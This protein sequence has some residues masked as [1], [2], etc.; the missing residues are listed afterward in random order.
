MSVELDDVVTV[1]VPPAPLAAERPAEVAFMLLEIMGK[2]TFV[3][4][5]KLELPATWAGAAEL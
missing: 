1:A 4:L 2:V 3:R 5:P